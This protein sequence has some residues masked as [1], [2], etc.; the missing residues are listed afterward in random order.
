VILDS[1]YVFGLELRASIRKIA[2]ST[3]SLLCIRGGLQGQSMGAPR[4]AVFRN[5]G[6]HHAVYF[7]A[8]RNARRRVYSLALSDT[9]LGFKLLCDP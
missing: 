8:L 4:F 5:V 2:I 6:F 7:G 9:I 1:K 3:S